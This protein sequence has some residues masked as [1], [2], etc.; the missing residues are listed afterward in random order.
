M[1]V[2]YQKSGWNTE[3]FEQIE[4]QFKDNLILVDDFKRELTNKTIE[5]AVSSL[6]EF[7]FPN[8]NSD[9]IIAALFERLHDS[10]EI[11]SWSPEDIP[12][13][14]SQTYGLVC[15]RENLNLRKQLA[16]FNHEHTMRCS[17]IERQLLKAHD[18]EQAYCYID[19]VFRYHLVYAIP[20]KGVLEKH[21]MVHNTFV[22]F[23][24]QL[25]KNH[26]L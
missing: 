9:L 11:D 17:N 1:K 16:Q 23:V 20:Q 15:A 26:S 22:G 2:G 8:P 19:R 5:A 24:D 7:G 10:N 13:V 4:T 25:K 18:I 6:K 12:L 14:G 3:A 21:H